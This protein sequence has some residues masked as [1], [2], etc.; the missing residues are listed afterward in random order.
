LMQWQCPSR[1]P[2]MCGDIPS[3]MLI[4]PSLPP[5]CP[6][7]SM[8]GA[9]PVQSQMGCPQPSVVC[10]P[11]GAVPGAPIPQPQAMA[12]L[13][14][15]MDAGLS[16]RINAG[17]IPTGFRSQLVACPSAYSPWT[18]QPSVFNPYGCQSSMMMLCR[19]EPGLCPW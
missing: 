17:C 4:C 1:L 15:Q 9:C 14:P 6:G 8:P 3:R 11:G 10:R 13:Q 16:S 5:G 18:C 7:P 12:G 2:W 19:T